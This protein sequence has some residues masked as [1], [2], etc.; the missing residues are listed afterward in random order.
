MGFRK[1][2]QHRKLSSQLVF[3]GPSTLSL[4]IVNSFACFS[5]FCLISA[6]FDLYSL[7]LAYVSRYLCGFRKDQS[8]SI[9]LKSLSSIIVVKYSRIYP[10]FKY[11]FVDKDCFGTARPT[12][13][14][15]NSFV[16][17]VSPCKHFTS[18]LSLDNV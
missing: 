9:L 12:T 5:F 4:L 15:N 6:S 14:L 1:P 13:E 17:W 2:L 7:G 8:D 16:F 11:S 10:N 3:L 18:K